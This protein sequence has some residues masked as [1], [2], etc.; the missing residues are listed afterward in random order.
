MLFVSSNNFSL[1][2]PLARIKTSTLVLVL[3]NKCPPQWTTQ[4]GSYTILCTTDFHSNFT[5]EAAVFNFK[6]GYNLPRGYILKENTL[7]F[8]QAPGLNICTRP[9]CVPF[10]TQLAV[11][12]PHSQCT[13][14]TASCQELSTWRPGHY[15]DGLQRKEFQNEEEAQS[16]F[17]TERRRTEPSVLQIVSTTV[18]EEFYQDQIFGLKTFVTLQ[19]VKQNEGIECRKKNRR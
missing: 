12:V 7:T 16:H 13:P 1:W 11:H 3:F 19:Q 14:H 9:C 18:F 6:K 4:P 10:H 15:V 2:N 8:N 17:K 5:S